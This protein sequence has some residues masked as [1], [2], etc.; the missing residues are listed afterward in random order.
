ML[1]AFDLYFIN[2]RYALHLSGFHL[3]VLN[4][5][6]NFKDITTCMQDTITLQFYNC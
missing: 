4:F 6:C 5:N 1:Y 2:V 3:H